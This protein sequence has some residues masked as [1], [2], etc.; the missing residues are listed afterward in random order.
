VFAAAAPVALMQVNGVC[1][2]KRCGRA[3][4][5][6]IGVLSLICVNACVTQRF[7]DRNIAK[8]RSFS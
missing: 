7:I 5:R 4:P 2:L 3:I 1:A 8:R 6:P